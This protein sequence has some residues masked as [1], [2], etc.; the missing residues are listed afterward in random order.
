MA[1]D[2]EIPAW[3]IGDRM[4]KALTHAGMTHQEMADHLGV[5]PSTM[6]TWTSGKVRPRA[7]MLRTWAIR[8]GVPYEWLVTG[9]TVGGLDSELTVTYQKAS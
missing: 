2:L 9:D 1:T 6:R 5:N 4:N 7:G 8:C 3:T